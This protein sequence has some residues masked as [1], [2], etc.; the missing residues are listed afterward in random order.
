MADPRFFSRGQPISIAQIIET[1]GASV[2]GDVKLSTEITDVAPLETATVGNI[3]FLENRRYAEA[4]RSSKATA[5]F[6]PSTLV[7]KAPKA[8]IKLVTEFPRRSYSK[9]SQLLYKSESASAN[10]HEAARISDLAILGQ[11]CRIEAGVMIGA[12]CEI[13]DCCWIGANTSI[14]AGVIIGNGTRVGSNVS[15]SHSKIGKNCF[16]YPGVR[17]GQPGFGFEIDS[18]GPIE[19]PQLGRVL[20]GNNVEI[21]ANSTVDRGAGPDTMIGSGT[22][23]DNLVQIG[24]NVEIGKGCVIVAQVGISGSTK[25]GDRSIVGGQVGLAGHLTIGSDVKIAAQSGVTRN[26][27]DGSIIGGSPA[28]PISEFRRQ[29]ARIKLL[30][31]RNSTE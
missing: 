5:C 3:T 12:F 30:G 9:I 4:V 19:M 24:H 22:R 1:T 18:S 16:I 10:I 26:V 25:I 14:D 31:R 13:G 15:I 23:I 8:M 17:I 29:V 21:G 7:H 11:D 27:K 20:I 28:V 6:L 2:D